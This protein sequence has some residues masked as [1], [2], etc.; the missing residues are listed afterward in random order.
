MTNA[1]RGLRDFSPVGSSL[2]KKILTEPMWFFVAGALVFGIALVF[3]DPPF[4]GL[5][6]RAHFMRAYQMSNAQLRVGTI[7]NDRHYGAELPA[8]L[9]QIVSLSTFD[10]ADNNVNK[11]LSNRKDTDFT[12]Y[13]PYISQPFSDNNTSSPLSDNQ[14]LAAISYAPTGYA[15]YAATIR[16]FRTIH[17]GLLTTMY[18][19]RLMGLFVYIAVVA[20][21][22]R[23]SPKYKWLI[24]LTAL[25]PTALF[26]A[27]VI[28]IDAVVSCASLLLFGLI[29]ALWYEPQKKGRRLELVVLG[30]LFVLATTKPPYAALALI[31]LFLPRKA[32][33]STKMMYFWKVAWLA[34]PVLV[35]GLWAVANGPAT[36]HV[37]ELLPPGTADI[38]AQLHFVLRRPFTFLR[39][40]VVTT[41]KGLDGYFMGAVGVAGSTLLDIPIMPVVLGSVLTVGLSL[42][43]EEPTTGPARSTDRRLSL[44]IACGLVATVS[45]ISASLYLTFTRVGG[46]VIGGIQGRYF[47]PLVPYVLLAAWL[48]FPWQVAVKKALIK[49]VMISSSA[50]F[51]SL[52]ALVYVVTNY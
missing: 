23:L 24:A 47:L 14:L 41:Y 45:L 9:V 44:A 36:K 11:G 10:L 2:A 40:L 39:V 49:R 20:W 46:S 3:I 7:G 34:V 6:E 12:Q 21:A 19:T 38:S 48:V 52:T 50:V 16:I 42:A 1:R 18:A 15:H 13:K 22:I 8:N 35:A 26:Q 17:V 43:Y 27:T 30:V 29:M 5:D 31:L 33:G 32:F 28:S 4:F 51:L 37:V 25:L